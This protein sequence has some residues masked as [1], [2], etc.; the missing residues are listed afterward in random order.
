[1]CVEVMGERC[2]QNARIQRH[3]K[4]RTAGWQQQKEGAHRHDDSYAGMTSASATTT[5]GS[6]VVVVVVVEAGLSS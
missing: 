1:M 3:W 6:F 4:A 2:M 5:L